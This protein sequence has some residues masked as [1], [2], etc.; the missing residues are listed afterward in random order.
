M[1]ICGEV[2]DDSK[3][4]FMSMQKM[5]LRSWEEMCSMVQTT[6]QIE[7]NDKARF[8]TRAAAVLQMITPSLTGGRRRLHL[9]IEK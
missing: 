8:N 2:H 6:F 7:D 4:L 9:L 1:L 3:T 5:K